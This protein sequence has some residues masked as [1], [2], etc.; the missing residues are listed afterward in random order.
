MDGAR[1]IADVTVMMMTTT[2]DGWGRAIGD[3]GT[4]QFIGEAALGLNSIGGS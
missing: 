4:A 3:G 1:W 2:M